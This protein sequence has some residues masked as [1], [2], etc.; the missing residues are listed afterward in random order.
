MIIHDYKVTPTN[1][2]YLEVSNKNGKKE[3]SNQ[4][5]VA[6]RQEI[7]ID[8]LIKF[9]N[10]KE[11]EFLVQSPTFFVLRNFKKEAVLVSSFIN[12]LN[13]SSVLNVQP[14]SFVPHIIS[15]I[16]KPKLFDKSRS[17]F[18]FIMV[19]G[20]FDRQRFI[21]KKDFFIWIVMFFFFF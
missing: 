21:V 13:S 14:S 9:I 20:S 7:L 15:P 2:G 19:D 12:Q 3:K 17:L 6:L 4:N 5:Q 11:L 1:D 8:K 16:L 18:D 10:N